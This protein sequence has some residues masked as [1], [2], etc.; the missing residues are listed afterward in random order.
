MDSAVTQ[1]T[2]AAAVGKSHAVRALSYQHSELF[3]EALF[4]FWV[5][6]QQD[7]APTADPGL[8]PPLRVPE[9]LTS[10]EGQTSDMLW[11][12]TGFSDHLIPFWVWLG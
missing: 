8:L 2:A 7:R 11:M 10:C 1:P 6:A 12:L 9:L 4:Y 5:V 3:G